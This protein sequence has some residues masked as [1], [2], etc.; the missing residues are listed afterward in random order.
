TVHEAM[1]SEEIL[2]VQESLSQFF[3]TKDTL[4]NEIHDLTRRVERRQE[5]L[6]VL[7]ESQARLADDKNRAT[8]ELERLN[9]KAA[10]SAL[11]ADQRKNIDREIAVL[12]DTMQTRREE[13][14]NFNTE[15]QKKKERL[16]E[17]Q[18]SFRAK[19]HELSNVS[20]LLNAARLEIAKLETRRDD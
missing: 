16:F 19:Q 1:R 20:S 5:R 11:S 8:R 15:E 4:V 2:A 3:K 14:M 10:K 18:K 12:D 13:I 9:P 6:A 17:L 7:K